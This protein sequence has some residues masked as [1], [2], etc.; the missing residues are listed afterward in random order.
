VCR[1]R[2]RRLPV[3]AFT[4]RTV[5]AFDA[6][7]VGRPLIVVVD[8]EH[9]A[10][11]LA[12]RV[13]LETADQQHLHLLTLDPN[14]ELPTLT[15]GDYV[16][17]RDY[18]EVEYDSWSQGTVATGVWAGAAW[19]KHA[20][21]E[22]L[23]HRT[24]KASVLRCLLLMRASTQIGAD[25][26]VS[27]RPRILSASWRGQLAQVGWRSAADVLA[28]GALLGR[29][30]ENYVWRRP[31]ANVLEY[32]PRHQYFAV[33]TRQALPASWRFTD[34]CERHFVAAL[35]ATPISL[36]TTALDRVAQVLP[37]RDEL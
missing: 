19:R 9:L 26:F 20:E 11:N 34:A 17:S 23:E 6:R 7:V 28:L 25:A 18:Y 35:E 30:R 36:A 32:I 37:I 10:D 8:R 15:I 27:D 22:S 12:L 14:D 31:A 3:Y 2:F 13:L 5:S 29:S 21:Q 24:D 16:E 1:V 4:N 33:A